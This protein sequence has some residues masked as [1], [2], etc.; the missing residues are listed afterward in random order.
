M[1]AKRGRGQLLEGGMMG[2]EEAL[3]FDQAPRIGKIQHRLCTVDYVCCLQGP[4]CH[5]TLGNSMKTDCCT[6]PKEA[7]FLF[8][9]LVL[10]A[11]E[12]AASGRIGPLSDLT[13]ARKLA[14][15]ASNYPIRKK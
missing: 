11:S 13:A 8:R 6:L 2:E 5:D 9:R 15:G 14:E 7:A 1:S 3:L 4:L 10:A 12:R